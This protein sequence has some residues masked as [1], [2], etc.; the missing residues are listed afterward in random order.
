MPDILPISQDASRQSQD[1]KSMSQY[2]VMSVDLNN[3]QSGNKPLINNQIR[4]AVPLPHPQHKMYPSVMTAQRR[5]EQSDWGSIHKQRRHH[6]DIRNQSWIRPAY[7]TAFQIFRPNIQ[8]FNRPL[9][10]KMPEW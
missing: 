10:M 8:N 2:P 3:W 4:Q 1:I 5:R 7:E 9:H 6:K